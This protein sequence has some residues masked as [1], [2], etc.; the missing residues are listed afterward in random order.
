MRPPIL[1]PYLSAARVLNVTQALPTTKL[2]RSLYQK[3]D[4]M[5]YEIARQMHACQ[6]AVL[7]IIVSWIALSAA[8]H[9]IPSIQSPSFRL[10]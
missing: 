1:L 2:R 6:N 10:L 4:S 5:A 7:K 9:R 8:Q 3:I